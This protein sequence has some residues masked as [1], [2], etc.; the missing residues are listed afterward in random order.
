MEILI[1]NSILLAYL[2]V[3]K[4]KKSLETDFMME[5]VSAILYR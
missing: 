5:I 3:G 4:R 1:K 2:Q